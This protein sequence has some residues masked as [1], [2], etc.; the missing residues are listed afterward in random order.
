MFEI[1]SLNCTDT[2]KI[3]QGWKFE[4][5]TEKQIHKETQKQNKKRKE[6]NPTLSYY[7]IPQKM[8]QKRQ[9]SQ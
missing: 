8:Q 4:L 6:K 7:N 2:Q 1:N 5:F 3:I 9:K